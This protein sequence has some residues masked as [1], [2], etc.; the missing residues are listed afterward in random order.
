MLDFCS[1]FLDFTQFASEESRGETRALRVELS[2][3]QLKRLERVSK[4]RELAVRE[5][6]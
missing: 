6:R 3:I 4:Q 2:L 1:V 5:R